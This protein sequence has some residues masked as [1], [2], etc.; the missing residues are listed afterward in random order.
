M[1]PT[2]GDRSRRGRRA[3][4]AIL[5]VPLVLLGVVAL[6]HTRAAR[7]LLAWMGASPPGCPVLG[8]PKRVEAA[9]V[10]SLVP[11]RGTTRA[12]SRPALTFSL[13]ASTKADALAWAKS[14]GVSCGEEL[15]G[16]ALRCRDVPERASGGGAVAAGD[17]SDLLFR[18]DPSG[19]MV[20]LDAVYAGI[21][22]EAAADSLAEIAAALTRDVGPPASALG[23]HS[24]T[25]LTAAP[26]AQSGAQFR[27]RDYAAD[28]TA[29][30]FGNK[31]IVLRGQYRAIPD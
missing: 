3:I 1:P 4:L 18:F 17:I 26:Y 14:N 12:A 16:A 25:Y 22:G 19:T 30:N 8:D 11:L 15:A 20:S 24:A 28:V 6:G 10:A 29:T 13:M 23:E 27:F 21:S 31:G 9:R 2:A 5:G 7:P